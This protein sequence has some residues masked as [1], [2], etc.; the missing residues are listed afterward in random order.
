MD[1][2]KAA[3]YIARNPYGFLIALMLLL[4]YAGI[5]LQK[6]DDFIL[7]RFKEDKKESQEREKRL[8]K[9]ADDNTRHLANIDNN[10]QDIETMLMERGGKSGLEDPNSP[11]SDTIH[12][13][14]RD[15]RRK[16][17]K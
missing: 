6:K 8:Q 14:M 16:L 13:N 2:V 11:D 17:S 15:S 4:W 7:K 3:D 5:L 1:L 12:R 9:T 10:I